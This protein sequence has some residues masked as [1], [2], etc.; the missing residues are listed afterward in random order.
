MGDAVIAYDLPTGEKAIPT[1]GAVYA[2]FG[3]GFLNKRHVT[4]CSMISVPPR[5]FGDPTGLAIVRSS[6]SPSV[7]T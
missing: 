1:L 6:A 3:V 2:G 5:S 4:T 7:S